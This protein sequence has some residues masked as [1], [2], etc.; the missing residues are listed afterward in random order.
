MD[1]DRPMGWNSERR[2]RSKFS[3]ESIEPHQFFG[4]KTRWWVYCCRMSRRCHQC[5]SSKHVGHRTF[6]VD[7]GGEHKHHYRQAK[8]YAECADIKRLQSSLRL[9]TEVDIYNVSRDDD[10]TRL[11]TANHKAVAPAIWAATSATGT[12]VKYWAYPIAP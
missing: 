12:P 3:Y 5:L 7:D 10:T 2:G 1:Q 9:A 6:A 4:G 11:H 8:C